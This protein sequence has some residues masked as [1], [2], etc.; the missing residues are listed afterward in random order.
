MNKRILPSQLRK[1]ENQW[2]ALS[3]DKKR[4]IAADKA[5]RK[6]R[7]KAARKGENHPVMFRVLPATSFYVV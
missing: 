7:Q 5:S 1:Y 4:V 6:A 3:Q 2:V